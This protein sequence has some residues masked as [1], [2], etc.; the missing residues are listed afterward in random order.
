MWVMRP[1]GT[2]KLPQEIRTTGSRIRPA[3]RTVTEALRLIEQE[4]P[5]ELRALPRWTFAKALLEEAART[6]TKK[7]VATAARQLRQA[8]GNEGWLAPTPERAATL[9]SRFGA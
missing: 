8:L 3:I 5:K 9:R 4:L 7:D 2:V 1:A 6:G